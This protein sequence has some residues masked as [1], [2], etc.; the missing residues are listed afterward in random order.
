MKSMELGIR[1]LAVFSKPDGIADVMLN[2]DLLGQVFIR[3]ERDSKGRLK[4]DVIDTGE[5][6]WSALGPIQN[7]IKVGVIEAGLNCVRHCLELSS[8]WVIIGQEA[9]FDMLALKRN[10]PAE[11]IQES[12]S[13]KTRFP[14]MGSR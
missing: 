4:A 8:D 2:C 7:Y 9:E 14:V 3:V 5:T 1:P 6:K 12:L 11:K 10:L 13:Y